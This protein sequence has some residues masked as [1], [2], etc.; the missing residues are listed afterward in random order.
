MMTRFARTF[1]ALTLVG[2]V[3]SCKKNS[4]NNT[5]TQPTPTLPGNFQQ[6][7]L[8]SD[9]AVFNA[10]FKDAGLVNAWGLAINPNGIFWIADNGTGLATAY[11]STGKTV[12]GPFGIPFEG[13]PNAG[14]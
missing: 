11:D 14:A 8:V 9:T 3:L 7:N 10:S 1:I 6:V 13:T 12:V 2:S 4:Y 5:Y